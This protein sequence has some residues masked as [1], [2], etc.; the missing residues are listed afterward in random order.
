M[1][2]RINELLELKQYREARESLCELEPADIA[3]ILG[4]LNERTLLLAFRLLPNDLAAECFVELES[5]EQSALIASFSDNELKEV[6]DELYVDDAVD[7]IEEMPANMVRRILSQA[8]SEMR[9]SINEILKYPSD[10]AGSLMTTELVSLHSGITVADAFSAIRRRAIDKETVY[11]CY[12]KDE[13]SRLIGVVTVKDLLLAED[14]EVIINDIMEKSVIFATT[15]EDKEEVAQKFSHYDLLALP[16]VDSEGRLVGIITVDD[17]IDVLEEE[18]TEDIEVMAGITPTDKPYMKTG[19][20]ETWRKRIPWLLLLMVSATFT[21]TII[22]RYEASLTVF[23]LAAFMPMLMD[24]GGNAGGQASVTIIRGLS[25]GEIRPR[26]WFKIAWKEF[27]V[28]MLCGV[29]M[30]IATFAKLMIIDHPS[31]EVALVVSLTLLCG[32]MVAK[33]IGCTMPILAKLAHL[34]PAVMAS[35]FITAT[36]DAVSLMIYFNIAT[37]ILA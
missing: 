7:L 35:P 23:G 6:V 8:D 27:R 12:V 36:V 2:N 28:A 14:D 13:K 19:V 32:V 3:A 34:D 26:D 20:F 18:A 9:K 16:V 30:A 29:T 4:E 10:S 24:T 17:A 1:E 33:L 21:S 25:L 5:E 11:T 31:L 22:T 15:L 37:A